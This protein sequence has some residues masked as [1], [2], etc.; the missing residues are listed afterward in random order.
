LKSNNRGVTGRIVTL[1]AIGGTQMFSAGF[2]VMDKTQY[3]NDEM[4]ANRV[5]ESVRLKS[6]ML[7]PKGVLAALPP[8]VVNV[9]FAKTFQDD[10][11]S[12]KHPG[13]WSITPVVDVARMWILRGEG[14]LCGLF[15]KVIFPLGIASQR[16]PC[17]VTREICKG[18]GDPTVAHHRG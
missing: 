15:E 16:E 1:V 8:Q 2:L 9:A 11:C 17:L 12:F 5:L 10:Q 14:S 18:S 7:N 6:A 13:T 3:A 4:L